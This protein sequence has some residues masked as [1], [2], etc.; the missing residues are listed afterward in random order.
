MREGGGT[1]QGVSHPRGRC[2]PSSVQPSPQP[3][4]LWPPTLAAARGRGR[5]RRRRVDLM[6]GL[7]GHYHI[8][9][10]TGPAGVLTNYGCGVRD[11]DGVGKVLKQ[12]GQ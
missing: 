1:R 5:H 12:K 3:W 6:A 10:V 7:L 8:R 4:Q 11:V 2:P 9:C